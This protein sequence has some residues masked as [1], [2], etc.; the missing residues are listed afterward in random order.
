MCYYNTETDHYFICKDRKISK[1]ELQNL[2]KYNLLLTFF[3]YEFVCLMD[4][5]LQLLD[6][7]DLLFFNNKY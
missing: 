3:F 4:I 7:T 6:L 1:I 5:F 2:V